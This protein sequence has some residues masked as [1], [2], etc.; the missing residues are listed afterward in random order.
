MVMGSRRR[1]G[2]SGSA[3]GVVGVLVLLALAGCAA[4]GNTAAV[5]GP[6]AAGFWLGLWHGFISPV[7]FIVSLFTD[8]VGIYEVRNNGGWYDVGF[9]IGVSAVFSGSARSSRPARRRARNRTDTN[10]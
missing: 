1:H 8:T 10:V 4:G 2:P 9:M 6:D 3:L 7:T 5:A